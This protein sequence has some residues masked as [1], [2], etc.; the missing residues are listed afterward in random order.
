M[1]LLSLAMVALAGASL[2]AAQLGVS[3][4]ANRAM[5]RQRSGFVHRARSNSTVARSSSNSHAKNGLGWPNG[6]TM[7]IDDFSK[8][9]GWVY[10][11]DATPATG[12]PVCTFCPPA[13]AAAASRPYLLAR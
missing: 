8:T 6:G 9:M 2:A 3:G 13:A 5:H 1:K 10:S 11:W 4:H 12:N 7:N